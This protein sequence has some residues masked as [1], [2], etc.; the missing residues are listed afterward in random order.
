M[1]IGMAIGFLFLGG[2]R[3]SLGR[4]NEQIAAVV[5]AVFPRFP[6]NT[7]D[8]RY[9]LQAFRHLYVLA[10]EPRCLDAIDVDTNAVC[11]VPIRDRL[12]AHGN[13]AP[14]TMDVIT[15]ALLPEPALLESVT[16]LGPRYVEQNTSISYSV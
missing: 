11:H 5:C 10:V 9:H 14:T 16:V 4:S 12:R 13:Y 7:A 2:G 1:A 3:A 6:Y 15:P 8:N